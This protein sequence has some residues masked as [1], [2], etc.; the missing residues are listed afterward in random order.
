MVQSQ[1]G[2]LGFRLSY[3]DAP[4]CAGS[5]PTVSETARVENVSACGASAGS[6]LRFCAPASP[7][8]AP[9]QVPVRGRSAPVTCRGTRWRRAG[10]PGP[11]SFYCVVTSFTIMLI[12]RDPRGHVLRSMLGFLIL[13]CRSWSSSQRSSFTSS[14]IYNESCGISRAGSREEGFH[15]EIPRYDYRDLRFLTLF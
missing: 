7:G 15:R 13:S 11:S 14:A 5:V 9:G 3:T 6:A 2:K 1:R 12:I 10:T 8:P 4:N